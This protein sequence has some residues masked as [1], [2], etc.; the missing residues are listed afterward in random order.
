MAN[1]GSSAITLDWNMF[2][3]FKMIYFKRYQSF[4]FVFFKKNHLDYAKNNGYLEKTVNVL[5][6]IFI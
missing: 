5:N 2:L 3:V 6:N 4:C 1:Q